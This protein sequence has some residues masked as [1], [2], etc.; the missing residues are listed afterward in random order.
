MKNS[1]FTLVELLVVIVIV[2]ILVT[3]GAT[4]AHM[5]IWFIQLV[6]AICAW[7]AIPVLAV[8]AVFVVIGMVAD[9]FKPKADKTSQVETQE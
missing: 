7:I 6:I 4:F 5:V 3:L 8:W 2:S 9:A 1:A